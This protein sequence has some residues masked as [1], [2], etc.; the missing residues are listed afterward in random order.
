MVLVGMVILTC[1]GENP[2]NPAGFRYVVIILVIGV[3]LFGLGAYI[4]GFFGEDDREKE[5][6]ENTTGYSKQDDHCP[7]PEE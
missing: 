5:T 3:A 4:A 6:S 1:V 7:Y 2:D